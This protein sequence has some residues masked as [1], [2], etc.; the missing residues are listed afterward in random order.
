AAA[1]RLPTPPPPSATCARTRTKSSTPR[2]SESGRAPHRA[3][4]G[5]RTPDGECA[6]AIA[7]I[8]SR[9]VT[10]ASVGDCCVWLAMD[11]GI[12]D[13]TESQVR[14]PLLGSGHAV[15][16]GFA[17]PLT[18]TLLLASDGLWKYVQRKRI[19]AIALQPDL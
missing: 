9:D 7:G 19:A 5:E 14:K 11:D 12:Q 8:E 2:R 13:I 1:P 4:G 18:G 6:L 15:P 17:T 10:G 16:I 3:R